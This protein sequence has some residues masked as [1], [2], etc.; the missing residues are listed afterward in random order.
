MHSRRKKMMVM[1]WALLGLATGWSAGRLMPVSRAGVTGDLLSGVV[2]SV[3]FAW[4]LWALRTGAT[5]NT[6][7]AGLGGVAG[8]ILLTFARRAYADRYRRVAA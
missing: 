1:L 7:V 8:A 6:L 4:T 5:D 3:V 2:G